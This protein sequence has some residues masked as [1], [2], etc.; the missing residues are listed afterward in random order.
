MGLIR[1]KFTGEFKEVVVQQ[2]LSGTPIRELCQEY[3]LHHQTITG[4]LCRYQ[5]GKSFHKPSMREK[6]QARQIEKLQ[7]KI[8]ELTMTIDPLKNSTRVYD[9]REK[10]M[11]A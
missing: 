5:E 4:W 10:K 6:I 3:L 2:V 8:G 1:R 7:A 9:N 11:G